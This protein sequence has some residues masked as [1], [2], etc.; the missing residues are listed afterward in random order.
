MERQ[1][2]Q[3]QTDPFAL[4]ISLEHPTARLV[5]PAVR[6][7]IE[8]VTGLAELGRAYRRVARAATVEDFVVDTLRELGVDW[9][10]NELDLA[11]VPRSGSCIVVA[12][13]PFGAIEGLLLAR[14][15]RSVRSDVKILANH[16]L[17]RVEPLRDTFLFVD[18]FGRR[19]A[20]APNSGAIRRAVRFL[21][22]GGMLALFPAGEVAHLDFR[23]GKVTEAPWNESLAHLVRASKA[24]VLPLYFRG[25]N[26]PFFQVA[27]LLHP[28]L[29]TALL[30]REL[31]NKRGRRIEARVGALVT[32]RKLASFD[33][34]SD[35]VAYLRERTSMLGARSE[36]R[37]DGTRVARGSTGR[38]RQVN[39]QPI[40]PPVDPA[41]MAREIGALPQEQ[42]L[43]HENGRVVG[44]ARA[45]QIPLTL[46]EIGRLREVTFRAADEGTGRAID[47]D[48]FDRSYLHLF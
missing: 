35:V 20:A 6:S 5:W 1:G 8:Q 11:R 26:G 47:L 44:W 42:V 37:P 19:D 31:L 7:W 4:D 10:V 39:L 15:L 32:Q 25:H 38:L 36:S 33:V 13:H 45:H 48:A 16:L 29:R 30:P 12:N 18:P 2:S 40:A 41:R 34:P 23:C 28:R 9:H 3:K 14:I 21:R 46:N 24:P 27:G 43:V 17:E 22:A